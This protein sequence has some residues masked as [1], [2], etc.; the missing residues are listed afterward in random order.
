M[1]GM[2]SATALLLTLS[3]I[4]ASP[5]LAE[6]PFEAAD[7]LIEAGHIPEA[8]RAL[9]AELRMHPEHVEARYNLAVLLQQI[10]KQQEAAELYRANLA[11]AW[12]LPSVINLVALLQKQGYTDQARQWLQKSTKQLRSEAAPWYLLAAMA[13]GEGRTGDA[14]QH[15]RKAVTTDPLNGFAHLRL[16]A[17]QSRHKLADKGLKEANRAMQLLPDCAPCWRKSGDILLAADLHQQAL[18]AYQSALAI[19]PDIT[20]RQQ[21]IHLL[22]RLAE[23]QRATRMQQAL[24]VWKKHY[25]PESGPH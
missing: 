1:R 20:T 23:H 3:I 14:R 13:E 4:I 7:R 8:R 10:D 19:K 5:A 21:L 25:P 18:K 17:F 22:E 15:Y 24:D 9:A 16:A 11:I 2:P 6:T 12:H